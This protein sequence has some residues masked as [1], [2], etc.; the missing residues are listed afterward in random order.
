MAEEQLIF[1]QRQRDML[2]H[3]TND[4]SVRQQKLTHSKK[5]AF[6]IE[7]LVCD[8]NVVKPSAG[9]IE[10]SLVVQIGFDILLSLLSSSPQG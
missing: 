10:K 8:I 1:A 5:I 3:K 7:S 9:I 2:L 4:W 6:L